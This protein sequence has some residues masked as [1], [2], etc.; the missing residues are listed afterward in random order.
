MSRQPFQLERKGATLSLTLDTPGAEVNVL[1][2]EAAAYL[3]ETLEG[4]VSADVRAVVLRSGKP[5]SFLNGVGLLLAGTM[6]T[7]EGVAALTQP[8]RAAYRALRH[9][10]VPTIAVIEGNCYGCGVELAMQCNY[11]VAVD[12]FDTHFRMTELADYLFLPTFGAT[13]DL[14]RLLRLDVAAEFLLWG[15]R[16]SA[17]RAF[18]VGLIDR[19]FERAGFAL[20]VERFV[21]K[22]ATLGSAAPLRRDGRTVSLEVGAVRDRE[23]TRIRRLPPAYRDL[24][25]SG[26]ELLE[27][28][29]RRSELTEADY[30]LEARE[31]ALSLIA[32]PCRAAWPFFFIRQMSRALAIGTATDR[33]RRLAFE[34]LDPGL[35]DFAEDLSYRCGGPAVAPRLAQEEEEA[36]PAQVERLPLRRYRDVRQKEHGDI[37]VFEGI[38]AEPA[39]PRWPMALYV[40]L[41]GVGIELVEV[42]SFGV[43][44]A[45]TLEV[46][47]GSLARR[48]G[49]TVLRTRP[50]RLFALDELLAAWLAPQAAYLEAG[51]SPADLAFSLR[52][53]G[54]TRLAGDLVAG[55]EVDAL[56]RLVAFRKP[57][58]KDPERSILAL[59]TIAVNDGKEDR[60]VTDA[61]MVSLGG[62]AWRMLETQCVRHP[63]VIDV[64]SRD[65]IDFPLQHTSL[66]RH[67]TQSR[68][69]RW[70]EQASTLRHLVAEEDIST[71]QEFV[72]NGRE[73]YL[74][75]GGQ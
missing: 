39:D 14:P 3:H 4:A 46:L 55:L 58:I 60:A 65:A 30:D 57:E 63:T 15:D 42:A 24:Y 74:G 69:M 25:A 71:L 31:A 19:C 18:E 13:Q 52:T 47:S 62:F 21:E 17:A 5:L 51:G 32:P 26:W 28:A 38:A 66:C 9:C 10:R 16:L 75:H 1:T 45:S 40:P 27:S 29:A 72:A 54:F 53:F 64:V 59:P 8:V 11:R 34:A 68:A 61:L 36:E 48:A 2:R 67:F 7:P 41:R 43:G 73:Y 49:F 56:C 50:S 20:E 6:K 35:T 23:L 37:G 12:T 44:A 22:V 33:A 70:L